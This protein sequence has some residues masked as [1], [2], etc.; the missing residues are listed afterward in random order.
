MERNRNWQGW[1]AVILAG[2]ALLVALGGRASGSNDMSVRV[3]KF[4]GQAQVPPGWV[5]AQPPQAAQ[6]APAP[7]G[8]VPAQPVQPPP[9]WVPAQP[10][11]AA[12]PAPVPPGWVPANPGDYP[13]QTQAPPAYWGKFGAPGGYGAAVGPAGLR[14]HIGSLLSI[15][16]RIFGG[17]IQILGLILLVG[18]CFR[19]FRGRGWNWGPPHGGETA[20]GPHGPAAGGPPPSE[21][22]QA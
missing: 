12:Q 2:L 5:P 3:A 19:F 11:Q 4:P 8:W 9:G 22:P 17:L 7:P 6:P 20:R 15:P 18:L 1:A 16:F 10:P 13:G 21:T 14:A